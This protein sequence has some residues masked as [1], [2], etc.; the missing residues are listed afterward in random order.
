VTVRRGS[1][2]VKR[3]PAVQRSGTYRVSLPA[4]GLRTGDYRV[5][6]EVVRGG[7]RIVQTLT[8]RALPASRSRA[9]R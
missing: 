7:E 1:R 4:R 3:Y 9:R 2:V 5:T 6:V 8:S